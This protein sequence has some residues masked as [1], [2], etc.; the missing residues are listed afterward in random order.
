[1]YI[2]I[3]YEVESIEENELNPNEKQHSY[4]YIENWIF[5]FLRLW[6]DFSPCVHM[7]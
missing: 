3:R 7:N 4:E 2:S 6:R 1:M 5:N